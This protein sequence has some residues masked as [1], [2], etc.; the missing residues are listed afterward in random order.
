MTV[1]VSTVTPLGTHNA[2]MPEQVDGGIQH[3][4]PVPDLIPVVWDRMSKNEPDR[5]IA[6]IPHGA[7]LEDGYRD[8][9]VRE[10]AD[11][12]NRAA[13]FL[14]KELGRSHT[15]ETLCYLGPSDLRYAILMSAAAK[16]GYKTFWTS[17]RNSLEGH[18]RLMEDT[19]CKLFLTPAAVPPGAQDIID[20]CNMRHV[21]VP[22]QS[23]WLDSREAVEEYRFTKTYQEARLD[24]LTVI[25][26][27]G[28]TGKCCFCHPRA[29]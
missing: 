27:S 26:T 1:S 25:H 10:M 17:P 22:E 24:P 6:S 4:I 29:K 14:D 8:V 3:N 7:E 21:I 9:T 15:F 20:R 28:S 13:W 12:I 18:I 16:T 5:V 11:A 23:D 2:N 19:Q